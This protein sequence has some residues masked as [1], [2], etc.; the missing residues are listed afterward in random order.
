[1]RELDF[2]SLALAALIGAIVVFLFYRRRKALLAGAVAGVII[3]TSLR[4]TGVS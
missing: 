3:Q 2:N 1:M 4:F